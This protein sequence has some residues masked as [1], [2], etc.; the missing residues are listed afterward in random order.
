FKVQGAKEGD[1]EFL[2]RLL[3]RISSLPTE[4][5]DALPLDTVQNWYESA[6]AAFNKNE[7]LPAPM[8]FVSKFKDPNAPKA[9]KTA[10]EPKEPKEPPAPKDPNAPVYRKARGKADITTGKVIKRALIQDQTISVA[11]IQQLLADAGFKDVKTSTIGTYVTDTME[12]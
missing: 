10:S 8:G 4:T 7:A 12:T 5:Y 1:N 9:A 11:R 2:T 3:E 6:A